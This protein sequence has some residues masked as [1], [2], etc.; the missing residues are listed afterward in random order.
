MPAM[1]HAADAAPPAAP[2]FS[3]AAFAAVADRL[4]AVL[5]HETEALRRNR[6]CD[7]ADTCGRKRQGLLELT[8]FLPSL[9]TA[10]EREG[11]RGRL[12]RL[13]AKLALNR[14]VLDVQIGAVRRVADIIAR[15]LRDA[16]SDGT[17]SM[18][19]GRS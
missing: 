5:D 12:G 10:E 7:L 15:T 16:E 1:P 2:L 9:A 14:Q 4:E 8:R 18:Q 11:A 3:F 17:Y 19:A 13:D 6:A